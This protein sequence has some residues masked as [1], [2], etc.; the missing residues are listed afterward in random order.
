MGRIKLTLEKYCKGSHFT[1]GERLKLQ[2][3]Y[4]GSNGYRKER[5]PTML[6]KIFQKSAKT[7]SRELERGMVEHDLGNIPFTRIEYNA[8]HAQL[9]AE[10][11][12]KYKGP[13]PK[14]GKHYALVQRISELIL[15]CKYSP[16][17]VLQTLDEEGLWPEGLRICEKTLY[18]WIESGDIPGVTI[19]DLPRKGNMKRKKSSRGKRKHSNVE[20]INNSLKCVLS[21]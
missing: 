7:I 18:N 14:S 13:P 3:Y 6:G 2:F 17:A 20:L 9:D 8:E 21:I 16:Y 5:S 15:E 19:E 4:A 1:W 11:K 10:E 12:M